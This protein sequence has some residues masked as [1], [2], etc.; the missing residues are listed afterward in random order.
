MKKKKEVPKKEVQGQEE[1]VRSLKTEIK[2]LQKLVIK[3]DLTGVLNRK[4]I[5]EEFNILFHE[6]FYLKKYLEVKKKTKRKIQ[7][8][9]LAILFVDADDFKKVND[10]YGHAIGDKALVLLSAALKRK[11]RRIDLIGRIG[12]EEFVIALLGA[13]E[14]GGY[15]KAQEIRK[16]VKESIVVQGQEELKLTVS[17]GVA[18]LKNSN[19]EDVMDLI[20]MADKAMYEAKTNRGKD[21]VVRHSELS[22]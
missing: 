14:K 4:G 18:S 9:N 12:G 13:T 2:R 21:C 6:A 20:S 19:A 11:I 16:Y 1:N 22:K 10:K 17:I 8:D 7:I 15:D 5:Q 3:D